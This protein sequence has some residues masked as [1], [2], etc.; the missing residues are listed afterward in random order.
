MFGFL[1][2]DKG[3]LTAEDE[4]RYRAVYCGLC[5]EL[6]S[7]YGF[8]ARLSL[9]YDFAFL[10]IILESLFEPEKIC[11]SGPCAAHPFKKIE[12]SAS[13][14][15]SYAADM[16]MVMAY[17]KAEDDKRDGDKVVIASAEL[18]LLQKKYGS[19][20]LKYPEKCEK[21]SAA[22]ESLYEYEKSGSTEID[23]CSD[24]FG[25]ALGEVFAYGSSRWTE[26]L[27]RCG[28]LLGKFIYVYD[29]C[30]DIERDIKQNSFNPFLGRGEEGFPG[31]EEQRELLEMLLGDF[32]SE[33][34]KLPLVEDTGLIKNII[35]SG[36]WQSINYKYRKPEKRA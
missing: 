24:C 19:V 22:L 17:L 11:S 6:Q 35:C 27:Y 33:L 18:A 3:S 29:A 16:S 10:I 20:K 2:A 36:V 9:T 8:A 4:K 13:E 34:D 25:K 1:I 15:T 7:Q 5:R 23:D 21:I 26:C 30:I 28:Y 32:V 31:E 14:I 12:S